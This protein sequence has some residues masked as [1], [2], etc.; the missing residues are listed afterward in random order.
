M[1]NEVL[2][3]PAMQSICPTHELETA[4]TI[5][6]VEDEAPTRK[7]IGLILR[8]A[9]YAVLEAGDG[10]T[11]RDVYRSNRGKIDLLLTDIS[12]P[13]A[14]G[15][16]LAAQLHESEPDLTVLFMSGTHQPNVSG[17]F[18]RKPFGIAELLQH[19]QVL[20]GN[21]SHPRTA[22]RPH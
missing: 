15:C 2:R 4:R 5:L 11:A 1:E 9:G 12:L 16:E 10:E 7:L 17:P 21:S 6:V 8:Q 20:S 3:E 14:T 22:Y 13:G 18:L 19:V